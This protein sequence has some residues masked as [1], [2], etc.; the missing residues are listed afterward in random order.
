M[1][2]SSFMQVPLNEL[3]EDML[4]KMCELGHGNG[5]VVSKVMHKSSKIVMARKLVHLE[6]K[7]SVRLQ[8]LK[9]QD[10][11]FFPEICKFLLKHLFLSLAFMAFMFSFLIMKKKLY[12]A[13]ECVVL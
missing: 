13:V 3:N 4:E 11:R 6:V 10:S 1:I 7:P 5:G 2:F 12:D 8:I 9:V